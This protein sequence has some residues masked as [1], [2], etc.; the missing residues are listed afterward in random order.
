MAE[1][2]NS[3]IDI[4]HNNKTVDFSEAAGDGIAG[5]LHKAT[6]GIT[7]KDPAYTARRQQ[8]TDADLLWGAYHF[9]DGSDGA[10]QADH[11]LNFV[12][13][14]AATLIVLDFEPNPLQAAG[15]AGQ[16]MTLAGAEAF[17]N[18]INE[19]L[20]R[21][22]GLYGSPAFLKKALGNK[23]DSPLANCWLWIAH[24]TTA[25]APTVPK[26]WK[27]WTIWQ[28]TDGKL[29]PEPHTVSGIGLCDRDR[30]N[31]DLAGLQQFWG[32]AA[33]ETGTDDADTEDD[34]ADSASV[35]G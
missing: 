16:T 24:Y 28:Y 20:G 4:S 14:D 15:P 1:I 25:A 17:V 19:K 22:P 7:F 13:P 33:Q 29:G 35:G 32:S 27:S 10:A 21:F 26:I 2:L 23:T 8:A 31:G 6:Q 30:F 5:V 12:N 3:V 9:G 34:T 18:R 11:F